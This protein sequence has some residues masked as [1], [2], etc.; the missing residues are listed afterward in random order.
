MGLASGCTGLG[1]AVVVIVDD[2]IGL[3]TCHF[4]CCCCCCCLNQSNLVF[5]IFVDAV[6]L[7]IVVVFLV[8]VFIVFIILV[9]VV[10]VAVEVRASRKVFHPNL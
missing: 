6:V 9:G 7:V 8:V 4:P 2:V 1:M 3:L 5:V 10:G